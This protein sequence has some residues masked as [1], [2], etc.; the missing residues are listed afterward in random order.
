M[1]P[2]DPKK[3]DRQP[4]QVAAELIG[5]TGERQAHG[6]LGIAIAGDYAYLAA[7]VHATTGIL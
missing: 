7:S 5:Q 3:P 4:S 6:P 1:G 2:P